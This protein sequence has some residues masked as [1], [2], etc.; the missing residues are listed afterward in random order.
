[1]LKYTDGEQEVEA[2]LFED[3]RRSAHYAFNIINDVQL[4]KFVAPARAI[5]YIMNNGRITLRN[6][7]SV[8]HGDY[9]VKDSKGDIRKCTAPEFAENYSLVEEE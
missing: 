9:I 1:M 6:G 3:N 4:D 5:D 7:E 2:L 8:S